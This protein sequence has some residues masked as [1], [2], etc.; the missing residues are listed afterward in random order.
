MRKGQSYKVY[1]RI[2]FTLYVNCIT[3]WIHDNL[4]RC[5]KSKT[6]LISNFTISGQRPVDGDVSGCLGQATDPAELW[7]PPS[8]SHKDQS[9][10]RVRQL[11]GA[12]VSCS[13]LTHSHVC[14]DHA[15]V[16]Y[17]DSWQRQHG[18][19]CPAGALAY[20]RWWTPQTSATEAVSVSKPTRKELQVGTKS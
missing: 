16:W 3:I 14:S 1:T 8:D 15:A 20:P 9:G 2:L 13:L 17:A 18:A 6:V 11:W 10:V 12:G 19:V 7:R 4:F 5:Y